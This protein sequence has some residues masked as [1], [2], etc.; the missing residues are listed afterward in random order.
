MQTIVSNKHKIIAVPHTPQVVNLFPQGKPHR[1]NEQDYLLIPHSET[2]VYLLRKLGFEAPAPILT[3]YDFPQTVGKPAFEVQKKTAALLTM[4]QRAYVLNGMGCVDADTEYLSETGW[5]RI[6]D[7]TAGKVAQYHPSSGDIE[8]VDPRE[9][10]KLPCAEMIR[11][12]TSRGVDQLL[13]PEHRVLLANGR[14]LQAEDVEAAYGSRASRDFKFR[15]TFKVKNAGGIAL[16]DAQIR[17]QTAV[18]ADG[19]LPVGGKSIVLR[20]LK[21]RKIIRLR[22][23]LAAAGV[24][25][26][27]VPCAPAGF[28]RFSFLPP[29]PKGFGETWWGC[30][31]QQLEVVAD[32]LTHWDGTFRKSGGESFSSYSKADADFAQ[33]AYSAAG[34]RTSLNISHH[35]NGGAEYVVHAKPGNPE[36]G[37]FGSNAGVVANNVRREPSTDGFKYCFMVPSTFLLLRRNGCIFATGNTGKTKCAIW[38]FLYLRRQKRATKMLVAA[39]LST[40]VFTWQREAFEVDPN[41]R[42]SILHGSRKQRQARLA[43]DADIYVVNH[44]GIG[45]IEKELHARADIDVI[46]IDELAV[47]RNKSERTK[48]MVALTKNRSWVWGM[49]GSPMPHEPTDV[50]YQCKVVTPDTVP[51]WFSHFRSQLMTPLGNLQKWV[52]KPDAVE[53]AYAVMQ[54]SVRFTIDEVAELP[55]CIER[56][57]DVDMGKLQQKVYKDIASHCQSVFQSGDQVTAANAGAAMQKL[58][59][60]SLGWVYVTDKNGTKGIAPLDNTKRIEALVDA[61]GSTSRKVLVFVPYIH[62]L[63]GTGG[64]LRDEN[65]D[66]AIVSGDT[67]SKTRNHIFSVFQTTNKYKVL[68]AHP[69]CVAHGITLTAADTVVWFGPITSLEI[70]DQANHRIRRV[71]Q[72]HKQQIIHLQSTTMEKRVYRMLNSKQDVQKSFLKMFAEGN[73]EW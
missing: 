47:Y 37:L 6:A 42:V 51:N 7:Y 62:A 46:C 9:F 68:L 64:A 29:I 18:N 54:P 35:K 69:Q 27:E 36:V 16:T 33:Y 49:T 45:V 57:V 67:P 30:T 31:Q 3:Q 34:K 1:F 25:Y 48:R 58:L 52:P 26:R 22:A 15:T 44:D 70:Y 72:K 38:S 19:H 61:I 10:I 17:L 13:S 63:E 65:I 53:Q 50:F 8:F 32:E 43:E 73:E 5:K 40:L 12:K 20:L 41:L 59:Q 66:H 28:V 39:P 56:Y 2:E 14:V 4:A 11:F 23:L 71:G 60:I 21:D 24:P 55:E